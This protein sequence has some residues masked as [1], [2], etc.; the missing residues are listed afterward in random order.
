MTER[1]RIGYQIKQIHC[2][3]NSLA[4]LRAVYKG[5]AALMI[6]HNSA[7]VVVSVAVDVAVAESLE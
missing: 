6:H 4:A 1:A 3:K 7:L 2:S 5:A